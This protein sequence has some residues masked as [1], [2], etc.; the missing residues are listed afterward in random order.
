MYHRALG[1]YWL[2]LSLSRWWLCYS[3]ASSFHQNRKEFSGRLSSVQLCIRLLL[4]HNLISA[5]PFLSGVRQKWNLD[6]LHE[7][8]SDVQHPLRAVLYLH[9]VNRLERGDCLFHA[10]VAASCHILRK[11]G[12]AVVLPSRQDWGSLCYQL[13]AFGWEKH[14]L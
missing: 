14:R 1:L 11:K 13:Q 2:W 7:E 10:E 4:V 3:A 9:D 8:Y 12:A 6:P 5:P